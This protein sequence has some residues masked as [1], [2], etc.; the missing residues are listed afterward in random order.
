MEFSHDWPITL[1][2]HGGVG[3]PDAE[4]SAAAEHRLFFIRNANHR[5]RHI[6]HQNH[7]LPPLSLYW[8]TAADL[9]G[10]AV[11]HYHPCLTVELQFIGRYCLR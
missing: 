5:G 4:N 10:I 7:L 11:E 9:A 1:S 2:R 6:A 8:E 3:Q